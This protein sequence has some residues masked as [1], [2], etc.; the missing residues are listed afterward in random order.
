MD[1]G[2]FYADES[3][4]KVKKEIRHRCHIVFDVFSQKIGTYATI[5]RNTPK[6]M[7]FA[8]RSHRISSLQQINHFISVVK[9]ATHS[10]AYFRNVIG[11]NCMQS[12]ECVCVA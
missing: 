11:S 3:N 7:L 5:L 10:F 4:L 12:Y 8:M 9:L 2:I 1:L 6:I